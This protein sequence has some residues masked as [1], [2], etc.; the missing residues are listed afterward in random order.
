VGSGAVPRRVEPAGRRRASLVAPLIFLAGVAISAFTIRRAL[1][2]FDEGLALQAARRVVQGQVPYRDFLWAYGPAQI[3]LLGGLFKLFGT[4]LIQWRIV[5]ALVDGGVALVA[6]VLLR[7]EAGPR[8]ALLGWLAAA[9]AI[10]QP[11]TANPFAFAFLCALLALLVATGG[12]SDRRRI[13]GAAV[14]TAAA[15]AFRLDFAFY[16]AV[17]IVAVL[18]V[19]VELP[20]RERIS[21]VGVYLTVTVALTALVYLPFAIADGVPHLYEALI[22]TS[23]REGGWWSLPFPIAYHGPFSGW[24]PNALA[25]D[26]KHLLDFYVPLLL[27]VGLAMAAVAAFLR[28]RRDR[29]L[30][31]SWAGLLVL[32]AGSVL[33]LQSRAD[34]FHTQPLLVVLAVLLPAVA[35]VPWRRAS[36]PALLV[37]AVFA[38]LLAHGVAN[39]VVALFQHHDPTELRVSVADGVKAP[40]GEAHAIETVVRI[41]DARVP[42]GGYIYVAPRRSD[43]A[44]FDDPLLY[45]LTERENPTRRDFGLLSR[46]GEQREAVAAL[47]RKHPEIV[48]R[49]TDPLSSRREPNKRGRPTGVHILDEYLARAYR[50]L[51]RLYHYD[52]LIRR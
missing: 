5:R 48:I 14:L 18:L 19:R 28:V 43:L 35:I 25:R 41:V 20:P 36:V 27:L 4:S 31:A 22:G 2:P 37:A 7:R 42:A 40:T 10:A 46:I 3:Y 13:L 6:Y 32:G 34:E 45:V 23:L 47:R 24:P 8:V 30:P 39:R 50:P 51:V 17:A 9:T 15:A 16:A 49:W 52:V 29:S 44:S 11:R 38:L 26:S 1:D 21:R 12:W 33:Y